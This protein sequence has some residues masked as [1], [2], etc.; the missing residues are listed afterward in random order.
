MIENMC[1]NSIDKISGQ[2]RYEGVRGDVSVDRRIL[3]EFSL[4]FPFLFLDW[5]GGE[6]GVEA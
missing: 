5:I 3:R 6:V 1:K 4:F 2:G